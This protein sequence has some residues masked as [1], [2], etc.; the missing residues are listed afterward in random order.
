MLLLLGVFLFCLSIIFLLKK[1]YVY[2][3][4]LFVLF[5]T[6]G[7]SIIPENLGG[8]KLSHLA[9]AYVIIFALLYYHRIRNSIRTNKVARSLS[10]LIIFFVVSILFSILYYD[11]PIFDT[12][13]TGLRYLVLLSFFVFIPLS[14]SDYQKLMKYLFYITFITS[15]LYILQ[16]VTGVQLLAYSL[17]VYEMP[18]ENG[19]FR[20]YN[21]PPLIS[22]FLY[23]CFFYKELIPSKFRIIAAIVFLLAIF[24]SNG[25]T[26]IMVMLMTFVG[27]SFFSGKLKQSLR[28]LVVLGIVFLFVQPLVFSRMDHGGKTSEDI[29]LVL[30]RD[31][32]KA[33]YQSQNGYTLLYR[34]AWINERWEYL[35]RRPVIESLFGLGLLTD[36][37]PVVQRKYH[38]R[39]GL[40]NETTGQTA[41]IRT[42][43]IAWGNFLTCYGFLGSF[44]FFVF[45]GNLIKVAYKLRHFI[46][47]ANIL[48]VMMCMSLIGSFSGASLSEPYSLVGQFL[49]FNYIKKIYE[50]KMSQSNCCNR[51]L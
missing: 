19:L 25:R 24:L 43:D 50:Y 6:K 26:S 42:P 15:I 2:S 11:F 12:I 13:I 30:D 33:D 5:G 27:I 28:M 32:H 14:I 1:K 16:C 38:F 7:L 41:Q 29:S 49:F 23:P 9:F 34:F 40:V 46:G 44:L 51:M 17:E 48:F 18:T 47:L 39:F 3:V 10:W 45:Y 31:F 20:F 35:S 22:L 8:L 21:Q 37:H 36:E 4:L